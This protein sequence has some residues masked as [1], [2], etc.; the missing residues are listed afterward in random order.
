MLVKNIYE[1]IGKTPLLELKHENA[2]I[3]LKLENLN[4]GGS[5]KDRL[6]MQIITDAEQSGKITKNTEIIEAT[7]GNTGVGLAMICAAKGYK[8][9][10]VM[11]ES[12]SMER[13]NILEAYGANL[14]LT[15]ANKGMKGA[16]EK[17]EEYHKNKPESFMPRQFETESN[18]KAHYKTT[19]VEIFDDLNGK[20]DF[21]IAGVGTGGTFTG[22][23]KYLKERIPDIKCIAVE[24]ANSAV[25]SGNDAGIHKIQGIGAGFAPKVLDKSLIDN[26]IK[27]TNEEAYTSAKELASKYGLLSGISAGANV[28][29]ALQTAAKA[30]NKGKTIVTVIPDTGERYLSTDLFNS[31]NI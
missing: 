30:E 12:M 4:P 27:V 14:I 7:S 18:A 10:I 9:T 5:V 17:A 1:L 13:R 25:L 22:V 24:P 19:A 6:A 20:I 31:N 29:A 16:I 26:I 3:F 23:S 15:P 28:F 11:P 2:R 21:F 8:L